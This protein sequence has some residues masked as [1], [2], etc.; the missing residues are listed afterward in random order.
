MRTDGII[1]VELR[2]ELDELARLDRL[3]EI[4]PTAERVGGLVEHRGRTVTNLCSW[5]YLGLNRHPEICAAAQRCTAQHGFG[6][7]AARGS[8]GTGLEVLECESRIARFLCTESAVLMSSRNQAILTIVSALLNERDVLFIE[9]GSSSPVTDAVEL[10]GAQLATFSIGDSNSLAT[11]LERARSA[12]RRIIF[13]ESISPISGAIAP[14]AEYAK[15]AERLDASLI[16][17]ESFALGALGIRGAGGS[18]HAAVASQV[19]L[20]FADLN[21]A[22][23]GS[24]AFI[25][26]NATLIGYLMNRSRTFAIENPLP[27]PVASAITAALDVIE[28]AIGKRKMIA[29]FAQMAAVAFGAV[30]LD[31]VEHP[32]SP[33]VAIRFQ[34]LAAAQEFTALLFQR[35]ILA[36]VVPFAAARSEGAVVRMIMRAGLSEVAVTGLIESVTELV[37]NQRERG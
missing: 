14:I 5:D 20:H 36:E 30:G 18:E 4:V 19:L 17:D 35:G 21:R 29:D 24:G 11:G 26:G 10:S 31:V 2:A 34:K 23:P 15:L 27:A 37:V 9:D 32:P 8:A 22:V 6:I 33:I 1:T 3:T 13:A 7:A 25:A 28:L 12:R 16:V